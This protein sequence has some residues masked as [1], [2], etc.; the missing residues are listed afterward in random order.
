MTGQPSRRL[1]FNELKTETSF[2]TGA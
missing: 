1:S 2:Y